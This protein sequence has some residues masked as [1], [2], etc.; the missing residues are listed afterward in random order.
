MEMDWVV[1]ISVML[2]A[3]G[4]VNGFRERIERI[5]APHKGSIPF[6]PFQKSV[7]SI[8]IKQYTT[9]P[10]GQPAVVP[11]L[12]RMM[13]WANTQASNEIPHSHSQSTG[14]LR[15]TTSA[16]YSISSVKKIR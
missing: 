1:L 9:C 16:S 8:V 15:L 14:V 3:Q 11:S 5:K 10:S 7:D 13:L 12:P 4:T 2:V 6:N